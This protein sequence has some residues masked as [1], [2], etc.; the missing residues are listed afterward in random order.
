M[1]GRHSKSTHVV[2]ALF[3]L[4]LSCSLSPDHRSEIDLV[5]SNSTMCVHINFGLLGAQPA[6]NELVAGSGIQGLASQVG[7]SP[8]DIHEA[9]SFVCPVSGSTIP[10]AG[11]LLGG[12]FSLST[13]SP[14]WL[15]DGWIK[16]HVAGATVYRHA[17]ASTLILPISEHTIA[18]TDTMG[19]GLIQK[20]VHRE[21]PSLLQDPEMGN[22]A[23]Q[24]SG[25]SVPVGVVVRFGQLA[26]DT[27]GALIAL[28]GVAAR[29]L[30]FE[31][32]G[33]ILARIGATKGL[34]C[35]MAE[36]GK[37]IKVRVLAVMASEESA[38]FVA[39]SLN[40][41]SGL[42]RMAKIAGA[43]QAN[44]RAAPDLEVARQGCTVVILLSADKSLLATT[45]PPR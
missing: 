35:C 22:L 28:A 1:R 45:G 40:L 10:G 13:L 34:A 15:G 38:S 30:N 9:C 42:T 4:L 44:G 7:I 24:I 36:D 19:L 21:M 32:V 29:A 2:I 27:E 11:I 23:R 18:L 16:D 43:R 5:P 17:R 20:V 39:G 26:Q 41:I 25:A 8:K 6:M 33:A 12:S 14:A 3:P 31:P 37:E